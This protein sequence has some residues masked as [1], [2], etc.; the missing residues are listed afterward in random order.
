MEGTLFENVSEC[1]ELIFELIERLELLYSVF[2]NQ[3]R[4]SEAT[5]QLKALSSDACQLIGNLDTA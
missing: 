2:V 4:R 5:H 1:L 3:K